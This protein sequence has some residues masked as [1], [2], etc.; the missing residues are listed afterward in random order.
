VQQ[1]GLQFITLLRGGKVEA[2]AWPTIELTGEAI[3][4]SLCEPSQACAPGK[5]LPDQAV[6]GR[7]IGLLGGSHNLLIIPGS[8]L[9][10]LAPI[11]YFTTIS[12]P[13]QL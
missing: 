4:V 7:G 6:G 13:F 11:E 9:P 12:F 10:M 1:F 2:F 8:C 5:K 3:A